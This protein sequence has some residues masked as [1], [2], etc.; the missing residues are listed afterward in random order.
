MTIGGNSNRPNPKPPEDMEKVI[1]SHRVA[2]L[3]AMIKEKSTP[4]EQDRRRVEVIAIEREHCAKLIRTKK[5]GK[6]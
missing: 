5:G 1:E 4:V 6:D 3:N 2:K